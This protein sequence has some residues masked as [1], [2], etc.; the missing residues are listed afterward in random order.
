[1]AGSKEEDLEIEVKL[2]EV[3]KINYVTLSML[4]NLDMSTVYPKKLKF[5]V[6]HQLEN[7]KL[8]NTLSIPLQNEPD[9]R[10]SYFKELYAYWI[11]R[12]Y[13]E[14]KIRALNHMNFPDA[15]VYKKWKKRKF[16]DFC[17]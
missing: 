11:Y 3:D 4:E 15:P 5:T 7:M 8:L 2:K 12:G 10:L 6:N 9:D 17:R 13:N 16:L 1:M 14:V